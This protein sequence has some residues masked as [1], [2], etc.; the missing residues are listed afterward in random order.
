MR[1]QPFNFC[2]LAVVVGCA[3]ASE[4]APFFTLSGGAPSTT[5]LHSFHWVSPRIGDD[6]VVL[7]KGGPLGLSEPGRVA[8]EYIGKEAAY[9]N[10]RFRWDGGNIFST[11][12]GTPRTVGQTA[13]TPFPP[14]S[15]GRYD[16]PADVLAGPLP[17]SFLISALAQ[18]KFNDGNRHIAFWPI[19]GDLGA[20]PYNFGTTLYAMLDDGKAVDSDYDDMIVRLTVG[21]ALPEPAG[22]AP[23]CVAAGLLGAWLKRYRAKLHARR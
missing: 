7:W 3:A 6:Q 20:N 11:G 4:A 23:M 13:A 16:V 12:A 18:E 17:F 8:I 10:T 22:V 9:A 14:A 5:R 2:V 15:L 21:P 1:R 19:P